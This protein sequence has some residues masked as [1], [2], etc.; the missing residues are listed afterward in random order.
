[1]MAVEVEDDDVGTQPPQ[2]GIRHR[3]GVAD[4]LDLGV[5][6]QHLAER[7]T[8]ERLALDDEDANG[9]GG[10]LRGA[11]DGAEHMLVFLS[12]LGKAGSLVP[13]PHTVTLRGGRGTPHNW[14]FLPRP[15]GAVP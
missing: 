14:G 5:A 10:R 9:L 4:D 2:R 8:E 13:V 1:M 3:V 11:D 15:S 7:L 6:R 12:P